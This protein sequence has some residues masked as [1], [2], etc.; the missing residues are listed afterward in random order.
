MARFLFPRLSAFLALAVL[1]FSASNKA[2]ASTC[3][4]SFYSFY[5]SCV[6]FGS[7][8][9]FTTPEEVIR[10][11]PQCFPGGSSSSQAQVSGSSFQQVAAITSVLQGRMLGNTGPI[12]FGSTPMQGLAAGGKNAWNVWANI[13]TNDTKQSYSVTG[14]P[15]RNDF[16][17][18]NTVI[19]ADYALA[20]GMVIGVSGA[21]DRGESG[22]EAFANPRAT[23]TTKGYAIAP[24]IGYQLGKE[25][26]LDA[27]VG[28]GSG[29]TNSAGGAESEADR[30]FYAANLGYSSWIKDLQLTGKLGYLHGEED[31]GQTK[32]NGAPRNNTAIKN[33]LDRWQLGGQLGYWLG[34]GVMP[35]ASL[36][37]L[38]DRRGSSQA[39]SDPIGKSAW[40]WALGVNFFSLANGITGG[41]VYMQEDNRSN[42][43]SDGVTAN[44]GIRF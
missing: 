10:A 26:A 18:Q 7:C 4:S 12:E 3:D 42:Q 33:K 14:N 23:T 2:S 22:T 15:I 38:A 34:N 16:K 11:H 40:Q 19:G 29:K 24:Y 1:F 44:I 8:S 32:L 30:L 27:S 21:L 5:D 37:Y 17:I 36:T 6:A 41:L 35:Y 20:P 9:P 31:F 25:L 13:G 43:K 39:G 28:L